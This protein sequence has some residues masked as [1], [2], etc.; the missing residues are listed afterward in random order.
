MGTKLD[1]EVVASEK[2]NDVEL[3]I[4]DA[5]IESALR[6]IKRLRESARDP[7]VSPRVQLSALTPRE[8]EVMPL[9]VSGH[10]A[11]EIGALLNISPRTVEIHRQSVLSK[12]GV[13]TT[14]DL[15]HMM[16]LAETSN[17]RR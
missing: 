3:L 5:A 1:P 10:S 13:S 15:I 14:I 12:L 6:R 2:L 11:R 7:S 16:N 17:D 8:R 4:V 9:I